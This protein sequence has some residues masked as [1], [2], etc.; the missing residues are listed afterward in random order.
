MHGSGRGSAT[1]A[2]GGV[3][4]TYV[5]GIRTTHGRLRSC[6]LDFFVSRGATAL[7]HHGRMAA[8]P[9]DFRLYHS[10]ALDVLAALL[11]EEMRAPAPGAPLLV[12]DTDR[13]STRLNSS[14]QCASRMPSSA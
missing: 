10:N 3:A 2:V 12:P 9:S 11:A 8:R 14:H 5:A 1:E 7:R 13:K 6:A 4:P